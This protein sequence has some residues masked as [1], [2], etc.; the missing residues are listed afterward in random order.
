MAVP[1]LLLALG[2]CDSSRGNAREGIVAQAG[3]QE[4]TVAAAAE[5][6]APQVQLPNQPEVAKALAELW[7][8]YFLLAKAAAE[9]STLASLD[10]SLLVDQQINQELVMQLRDKVIQVDTTLSEEELQQLYGEELPGGRVRARHIL[11]RVPEGASDAQVDSVRQAAEALRTRILAGE[12]F[13]TLAETYSQDTGSGANGGDLGTFGRGEMVPPFEAA[14]FALDVG[15][16]SPVVE[17]AFGFHIIR[18]EEKVIP[19]LDENRDQFRAVMQSRR[20]AEAESL[21]VASVID[22]ADIK[23]DTTTYQTIREMASDPNMALSSRAARRAMVTYEGGTFTVGEV[24]EWIQTRDPNLRGQVGAATDEQ[25]DGLLRNL[26]RGEL[27]VAAAR[28][29]GL[30]ATPAHRDSLVTGM[31]DGVKSLAQQMGFLGLTPADGESVDQAA[32]RVV[33]G[34]LREVV[35]GTREVFP[36]GGVSLA[37]RKQY[38]A[39]IFEPSLQATVDRITQL[40]PAAPPPTTELP[41]PQ[42]TLS[43]DT[44]GGQG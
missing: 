41:V 33:L 14:A 36:L 11:L 20:I 21:Y 28:K 35:Q 27:L 24:Q 43:P 12:D 16:V 13:A 7:I 10:M 8:D 38:R 1:A 6:L 40:R 5:I 31:R 3:G 32:N 25:L 9:D 23:V 19:P 39:E 26:T 42:D 18:V 29:E 34:V 17:T 15:E 37:L 2:A 30:E 4:L 44:A 22:S